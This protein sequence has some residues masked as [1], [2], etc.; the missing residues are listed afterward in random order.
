M[1]EPHGQQCLQSKLKE[2]VIEGGGLEQTKFL[3][4]NG[5][6]INEVDCDGLSYSDLAVY[7]GNHVIYDFISSVSG[8][9]PKIHNKKELV[10]ARSSNFFRKNLVTNSEHDL[11]V[12]FVINNIKTNL[13]NFSIKI[14]NES[15]LK[16]I[17][18]V[19]F[20]DEDDSELDGIHF[21]K[22]NPV[23]NLVFQICSLGTCQESVED[24][25]KTLPFEDYFSNEFYYTQKCPMVH[26]FNFRSVS[27]EC[28]A[29]A[30]WKYPCGE[31][32]EVIPS[33]VL[34]KILL[35]GHRGSGADGT[36]SHG[37]RENTI[38]SFELASSDGAEFV[39]FGWSFCIILEA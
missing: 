25:I 36:Q 34:N 20:S 13:L 37:L 18:Q 3:V 12:I 33:F 2:A 8:F 32:V 10:T 7:N 26:Q 24:D 5:A 31:R 16:L 38:E 39:E 23:E 35:I 22:V 19:L 4:K 9:S 14:M 6:N 15:N 17:H 21:F 27:F 1:L 11:A 28:V 29:F 30:V